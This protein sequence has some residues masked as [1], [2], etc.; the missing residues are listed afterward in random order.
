V[1]TD[2]YPVIAPDLAKEADVVMVKAGGGEGGRKRKEGKEES[3]I[4][5]LRDAFWHPQF[6]L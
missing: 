6:L 3:A 2:L 5:H 4:D 1:V